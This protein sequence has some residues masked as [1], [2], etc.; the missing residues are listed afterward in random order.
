MVEFKGDDGMPGADLIARD[1]LEEVALG[2]KAPG[3][4][5]V[6]AGGQVRVRSL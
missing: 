6:A 1:H 4:S 2:V 5:V 3:K